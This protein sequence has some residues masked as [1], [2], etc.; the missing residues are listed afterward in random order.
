[1]IDMRMRNIFNFD[2][3]RRMSNSIY[4]L[5]AIGE[6]ISVEKISS[7]RFLKI[8]VCLKNNRFLVV[9]SF[10]KQ[11]LNK[12]HDFLSKSPWRF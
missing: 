4:E 6:R 11:A 2:L 9:L 8:K 10:F 5:C 12:F 3:N 7:I 1:M